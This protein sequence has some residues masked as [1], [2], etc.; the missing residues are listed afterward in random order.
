MLP[1]FVGIR[2]LPFWLVLIVAAM[3][4]P[5]FAKKQLD[6]LTREWYMHPVRPNSLLRELSEVVR[7]ILHTTK[8]T[9][10]SPR[11]SGISAMWYALPRPT[12]KV[13]TKP[14]NLEPPRSCLVGLSRLQD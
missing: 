2:L 13:F 1:Q 5:E 9:A 14:A 8:R 3:I 11:T 12:S 7:L 6:L 4:D 10:S